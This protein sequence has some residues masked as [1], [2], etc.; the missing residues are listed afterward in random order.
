[1]TTAADCGYHL[2]NS[3]HRD[4]FATKHVAMSNLSALHRE[5]KARCDIPHVDQVHNKI[6]IQMNAPV[7]E[8][9]KHRGRRSEV[10]IMRPDG[11]RGCTN[12]H[13]KTG[14]SR[15]GGKPLGEHLRS[16]VE[17]RHLGGGLQIALGKRRLRWR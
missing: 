8:M 14:C 10:L 15:L 13:R 16:R 9:P 7:E 5:N 4:A 12:H 6:E 17:T 1:M 3:L 2:Q 11:H